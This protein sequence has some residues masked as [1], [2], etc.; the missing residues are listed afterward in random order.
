M[1]YI[2]LLFIMFLGLV[3]QAQRTTQSL[4]DNWQFYFA[5]DMQ[6]N[7]K[8]STVQIPHTWNVADIAQ[9]V[10]DYKRTTGV[11]LKNIQFAKEAYSGKRLFLYFEGV[12]S[13]AQVFINKKLAGEHK[14]GYTAFNFEITD[15]VELG[16]ENQIMVLASNAF[17]TDILPLTGDFNIMGGIHRPVHL[18]VTDKNC[19]TP[20][21]YASSGV[22]LKQTKVDEQNA[23]VD[24]TTKFS[25]QKGANNL[26]LKNSVYDALNKLVTTAEIPVNTDIAQTSIQ[27]TKPQL[28]NGKAN[29]YLYKVVTTLYQNG[30]AID[31]VI[32]PLGLRYFSV[33]PEKGFLLNGKY[34]DLYGFG[35]HEDVEGRGSALL[36]SDFQ[37]TM[38]LVKEV[39]ATSLR[40][41]HYPHSQPIYNLADSTGIV[42]WSEIPF[43]GP[44]GYTGTGY[45]GSK[46]LEEHGVE[47]LKEMI[48]QNYNHPSVFFWGLFNELK[49]DYDNPI[50]YLEKLN[51]IAKAED[52]T[53]LTV[54][55]SFLDNDKFN[56]TS[57]IIGWNKYYG[58]YGGKF[59]DIGVWAD[60]MHKEYPQKAISVS[61]YGAG[62]GTT[63]HTDVLKA[64]SSTGKFHPEE[65]QTAFHEEHWKE[66]K[67]RPFLW[68]KYIWVFAD[69][70]SS[71]RTEG[72]KNGMNDKG[73]VSYDR[74]IKKDAFY[75]YKANWNT[76]PMLYVAEKRFVERKNAATQIKVFSNLPE[77]TLMINGKKI[78][79]QKPN[80]MKTIVWNNVQLQEG[81]NTIE[82]SGTGKNKKQ[83]DTCT[84][85]V[86][87]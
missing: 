78:S 48:R 23:L 33:D 22:Y 74:S 70:S 57:D 54:C 27:I 13:F 14:G 61:E 67:K 25:L 51:A 20:L 29:P 73:L 81:K 79:T 68:G 17:R 2:S 85:N 24:I 34:L 39:G 8:K 11:Y 64:P 45:N 86:V 72:E 62:A 59:T 44:G 6:Q 75:F 80:E 84:F 87:K 65:W 69:F 53:R 5:Y 15:L 77:V 43:V 83:K 12:N 55:A 21:D 30:V 36:P 10:M 49:L 66:M 4:H 35:I 82:V 18:I 37:K 76:E 47:V 56:T 58:W 31:E 7:A 60:K 26:S 28:W 52:P 38:E 41:T 42:L 19:I 71:I 1:R 46:A 3:A 32:Q 40:L 16:K 63:M 50:P 9:G